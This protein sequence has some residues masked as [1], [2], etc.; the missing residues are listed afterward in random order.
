MP[1]SD[2]GRR[3]AQRPGMW[4]KPG[5][6]DPAAPEPPKGRAAHSR[7]GSSQYDSLDMPPV[8]RLKRRR[9]VAIAPD[10]PE[11]K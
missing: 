4:K 3:P 5:T 1:K 10:A 6:E 8:V 7:R 9:S 2:G 11:E